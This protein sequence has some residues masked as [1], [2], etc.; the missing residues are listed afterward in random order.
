MDENPC[1]HEKGYDCLRPDL[2]YVVV[3]MSIRMVLILCMWMFGVVHHDN[4]NI[5]D[6]DYLCI[7]INIGM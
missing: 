1:I 2:R 7:A 4:M 3:A 6:V 5:I